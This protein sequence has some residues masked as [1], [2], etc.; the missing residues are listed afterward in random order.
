MAELEQRGGAQIKLGFRGTMRLLMPYF[1]E[2]FVEQVK[3]IWF[4]I[5]YLLVFQL[6]ILDMPIVYAGMIAVGI[7]FVAVGLMFFMEGLR[8]GLMPLGEIIGAILPRNANMIIILGFAFLLGVGATFAEPAIAVLRA[9]GAGVEPSQAPLLYS[10]LNDFPSQLVMSVGVGVGIAVML[11]ILRF[12]HAWSLK[13]L[14]YPLLCVLLILTLFATFT[15]DLRPVIGLAWDCGAVTTGPV[16]V[17]LVIALGIG[18]CRIVGDEDSG[19]A[20]F[21]IVTLASLFPIIAVLLLAI[22]HYFKGDY[23][24]QPGYEGQP[25]TSYEYGTNIEALGLEKAATEVG[26]HKAA[27]DHTES[28]TTGHIS[29]AEFLAYKDSGLLPEDVQ[30]R[31]EG[32]E[33]RWVDGRII[34]KPDAVIYERAEKPS[35]WD[36]DIE[37]WDPDTNFFDDARAALRGA[38]QAII[39]LCAFL[40]FTLKIILREKIKQWNEMAIG[41]GFALVGMSIFG[42][43]IEIGLTPLGTQLGSNIPSSFTVITPWGLDSSIGPLFEGGIAGKGL[44]V[45][46]G[47]FLGYGATLAEPAL[48]ALG[49]TVQKITAGAFRKRLLM[50]AVALGVAMGIAA[51]VLKVVNDIPLT[52]MILPPYLLLL[53]LT[54]ISSEEFVNFAWDSAG[55]TT[56]PITVPLVLSMGLGIGAN[57]PG[58]IDGFGILALASVGPIL[59]VLTVGLI[60]RQTSDSAKGGLA[61]V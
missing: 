13:I 6:F 44:V 28:E 7:F 25:Q 46:F 32:G 38:I 10:L 20:G 24:G 50:Q 2:K 4:I 31:Y 35:L 29:E 54:K 53:V 61:D 43:G 27:N 9:A 52:W 26:E 16:T 33:I 8:L 49:D 47:F 34:H 23:W 1:Q 3:T 21:G 45:L 14:I 12:F 39:P 55:V 15:P 22:V 18:V 36:A 42:L 41:I 17:P 30:K 60:V 57:I 59:T 37:E 56:G 51:G 58:V 5:F 48:N 11:G 19:N 40:F